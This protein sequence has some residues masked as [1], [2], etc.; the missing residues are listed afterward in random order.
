MGKEVQNQ[1]VSKNLNLSILEL[2]QEGKRPSQICKILRMKKTAL[3]YYLSSLKKKELIK[4]IGYGVWEVNKKEVQNQSTKEVQK[5]TRI[6]LNNPQDLNLFKSDTVR[7][8]AFQFTLRLPENLRN[9]DKRRE[10]LKKQGVKFKPLN[11]YG[12]AE[13]LVFKGRKIWLTNKSVIVFEKSSYMAETS[14]EARKHAVY[15]FL[16]LIS[17]LE[18]NI[19]ANF[20]LV[21]GR[22]KFKISRQH[23]ALIK[24]SLA[25]QYDREGKKLEVIH[26]QGVWFIIDNSFNLHEAETI[27]PKT[28][29][30]DNEKVRV[31]FNAIK[32]GFSAK[33][34]TSELSELQQILKE[35]SRSQLMTG[36]V[37][38]QL[39]QNVKHIVKVLGENR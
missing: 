16:Q 23:Y 38:Q 25:K 28:A 5:T 18:R 3:Q 8:H 4:K 13:S 22:V 34:V 33:E 39:D 19:K 36:Q 7:G 10:L 27:H 24:N 35:S 1:P 37:L 12:G 9:W 20:G 26:N 2:L 6:G 11:L 31:F 17:S 29:E 21:G 14:E 15:D 30:E 32:E